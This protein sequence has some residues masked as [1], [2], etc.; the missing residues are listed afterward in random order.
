MQVVPAKRAEL[1]EWKSQAAKR[2]LL[3][4]R[5]SVPAPQSRQQSF[6]KLEPELI[7]SLHRGNGHLR[8]LR[9]PQ[10]VQY[11]LQ[12]DGIQLNGC[13]RSPVH[14]RNAARG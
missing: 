8:I 14:F 2:R 13:N 3:L 6:G 12:L 5:S 1:R 10:L 9:R 7:R 11:P 4:H